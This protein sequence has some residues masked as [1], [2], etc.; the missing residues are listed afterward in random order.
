MKASI[1]NLISTQRQPSAFIWYS[2]TATIGSR[3]YS[4]KAVRFGGVL[5][6]ISCKSFDSGREANVRGAT[7]TTIEQEMVRATGSEM[8]GLEFADRNPITSEDL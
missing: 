1:S 8:T 7:K 3:D 6:L 2:A 4:V 5:S